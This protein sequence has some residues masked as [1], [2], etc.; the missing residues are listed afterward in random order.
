MYKDRLVLILKL[1]RHPHN[2]GGVS[3]HPLWK[4]LE[5][6]QNIQAGGC[7]V[8]LRRNEFSHL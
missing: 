6:I 1:Y 5:V 3:F 7:G 8:I 2:T 4:A